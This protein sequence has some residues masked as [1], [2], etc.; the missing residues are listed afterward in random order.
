[1]YSKWMAIIDTVIDIN[2]PVQSILH[3]CTKLQSSPNALLILLQNMG[4][5]QGIFLPL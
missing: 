1:M 3:N 5:E 4:P 2:V